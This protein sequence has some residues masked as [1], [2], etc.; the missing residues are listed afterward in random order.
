MSFYILTFILGFTSSHT[1]NIERDVSVKYENKILSR[2]RPVVSTFS[3]VHHPS[4]RYDIMCQ[5]KL[6]TVSCKN[7]RRW[8]IMKFVSQIL[9]GAASFFSEASCYR[10]SCIRSV[11]P[12][13][14][15]NWLHFCDKIHVV[16]HL[17]AINWN[18]MWVSAINWNYMWEI[19]SV[20]IFLIY[21]LI[22]CVFMHVAKVNLE[23]SIDHKGYSV[24]VMTN[25]RKGKALSQS[26]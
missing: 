5:R 23:T 26:C 24:V 21:Q 9:Q 10:Y 12:A 15:F 14:N 11:F 16:C 18:Y 6:R 7:T 22:V 8:N 1:T 4:S 20:S 19:F 2:P 3:P 25:V 17:W 13:H